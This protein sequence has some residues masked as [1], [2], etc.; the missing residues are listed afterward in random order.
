[1][2]VTL[3]EIRQALRDTA[4]GVS[5]GGFTLA[6]ARVVMGYIE[7][8]QTTDFFPDCLANGPYMIVD[9]GALSEFNN[10][11][12]F[13]GRY[14]IDCQLW[15]SAALDSNNDFKN[16]ET[17]CEAIRLAWAAGLTITS[18]SVNIGV[19]ASITYERPQISAAIALNSIHRFKVVKDGTA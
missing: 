5:A 13:H 15:I 14:E 17:F 9:T 12:N 7:L 4:S 16:Q 3:P 10:L 2:A 18:G 19:P 6:D 1:M 8:A 11:T